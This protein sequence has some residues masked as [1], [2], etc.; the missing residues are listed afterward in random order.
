MTDP[1]RRVPSVDAVLRASPE[2]VSDR[3]R[4]AAAVRE[5]LAAARTAGSEILDPAAY[6]KLARD[7]IAKRDAP[8]LRRVI[9]ATGVVLHTNLGR[10]PSPRPPS[11]R[12][13]TRAAR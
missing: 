13:A 1:R 8:T 9:N 4:L 12:S 3:R 7:R 11:Q 10:A 6:A 5:V 2:D